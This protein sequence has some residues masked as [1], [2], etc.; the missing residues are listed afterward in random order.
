MG[1]AR[2]HDPPPPRLACPLVRALM[3]VIAKRLS[4]ELLAEG[5]RAD[6]Q[7]LKL[8]VATLIKAGLET[9]EDLDGLPDLDT[10]E[11]LGHL[12]PEDSLFLERLRERINNPVCV[13]S[14]FENIVSCPLVY[15]CRRGGGVTSHGLPLRR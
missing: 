7:R 6:A 4:T 14:L 3:S 10:L 11:G 15:R 2:V 12:L 8:L 1:G 5:F 9:I 13:N